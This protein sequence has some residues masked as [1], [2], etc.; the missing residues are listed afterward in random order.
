MEEKSNAH[1]IDIVLWSLR[2]VFGRLR[3]RAS[4]GTRER[5][6]S[7][8]L[9]AAEEEEERLEIWQQR[10]K[11]EKEKLHLPVL[12]TFFLGESGG[13]KRRV[14]AYVGFSSSLSLAAGNQ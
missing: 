7:R 10:K 12:T 11:G 3:Q 9:P 8:W 6:S 4:E 2:E 5:G 13:E 1:Q 14:C